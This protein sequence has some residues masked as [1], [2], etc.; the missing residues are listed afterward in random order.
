MSPVTHWLW[1]SYITINSPEHQTLFVN[2]MIVYKTF[3]TP[4][5][6]NK[7]GVVSKGRKEWQKFSIVTVSL[8]FIII[9]DRFLTVTIFSWEIVALLL[10]VTDFVDVV[11]SNWRKEALPWYNYLAD[12]IILTD[13]QG[14]LASYYPSKKVSSPLAVLLFVHKS[15][16]RLLTLSL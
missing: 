4:R 16:S 8:L 12:T 10:T 11:A 13:S 9:G 15:L 6:R 5:Y 1:H 7:P 3:F 14:F 2:K